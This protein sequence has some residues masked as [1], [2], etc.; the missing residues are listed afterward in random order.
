[1][2]RLLLLSVLVVIVFS[3]YGQ[4]STITGTIT[5][6]E[7]GSPLPGV[8]ILIKGKATGTVTDIDGN[9]TINITDQSDILIYSLVG[10]ASEE[11]PA[12]GQSVIDVQMVIDIKQLEELVV[13]G[14]GSQKRKDISSALTT[15]DTDQMKELP[16]YSFDV[17]MQGLSTGL[18]IATPSGTPGAAVNVN[19]RGVTSISASSQ[20]LY[21]IDG[22]PVVTKNSSALNSNIQPTNPLADINPSDI[23]SVTVLKDASAVAIYGSRGSNGVILINTKRGDSGKTKVNVNYYYG[24]SEIS[25]TPDMMT[26]KQWIE[27]LNVAAENDGLGENFWTNRIGHPDS[28]PNYNV[29][30]EIFRTASTHNFDIS[31]NGGSENTK[32]YLSA[33]YFNQ[34]GIQIGQAFERFS[35][36]FNLD[37]HI[38]DNL[39]IG[40]TFYIGVGNH[41]RTINENDEYGVVINAQAWDPTAPFY[42]PDG[43]YTNPDDFEGWWALE[44]PLVVANEYKNTSVSNRI[45]GQAFL[46]WEIINGLNFKTS[47]SVDYSSLTEESFTP[48]GFNE[49]DD[50]LGSFATYQETNF[51]QENTLTWSKFVNKHNINVLGGFSW[52]LN[53]EIYSEMDG[54]GFAVNSRPKL[55][56]AATITAGES[57][58]SSFGLVSF[59]LRLNYGYDDRYIISLTGRSDGSS[60]FGEN[61]RFGTF[62]SASLAWNAHNESFLTD[63]A[64]LSQLKIRGSYGVVGN[65]EIGNQTWTGKWNLS[66]PYREQSGIQPQAFENPDLTWE[67]TTQGNGGLDVGFL[68][69][70]INLSFD[71]FHKTT[72]KLITQTD[73]PG[74]SGFTK[75]ISNSGTIENKGIELS[76]NTVNIE[77]NEFKWTS[78]I[79]YTNLQNEVIDV[80]N[81]GEQLSRNFVLKKGE[82]LSSLFLVRFLG[83]DPTTGDAKFQDINSDGIIDLSDRQIVGSGIPTYF[84]S[85]NNVFS[86]KGFSFQFLFYF[87]G[88]NKIFNQ[89]RYAYENYGALASDGRPFGNYNTRSLNYWKQPGDITDIPRPSHASLGEEGA[90][91]YRFSSQY[92]ED[93]D[94]V[95]LKTVR[96][97]YSFQKKILT[98]LKL[99]SLTLYATGQ[100]LYTWTDY[101]GFDPEINTNTADPEALNSL[102]GEDFGTLGQA[103]TYTFGLNIGF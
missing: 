61:N 7:D 60:R 13:V 103:R 86:Y 36:R 84:G 99:R 80:I 26:S 38:K 64:W 87:S 5:S 59:M 93:G 96:L 83:V 8:N 78:S 32:F 1:M 85:F 20:P 9:Y 21:I 100:N 35:G 57:A 2:K 16:T 81:D 65:Q 44:N 98:K 55:R 27:F 71:Y 90:Q 34:E 56:N 46:N 52:Q 92:L 70:R 48:A 12:S 91:F 68:T 10:Y 72:E 42:N 97:S 88:G 51:V 6:I 50:G 77:K 102:Q 63:V 62:P 94:F 18:S 31:A 25:N 49:S 79:N 47:F 76:L 74:N 82:P 39:S 37:H 29:Y 40:S 43:T 15:I 4:E 101:T 3:V 95:R 69:N 22:I 33:N 41:D 23:E 53:D 66:S 45:Q 30:D 19:I 28:V 75:L 67:Q 11:I 24:I 54:Q 14:Y 58:G 73:I 89:S 17:A